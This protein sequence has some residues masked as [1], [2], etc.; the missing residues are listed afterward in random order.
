M[1]SLRLAGMGL[2][3][4]RSKGLGLLFSVREGCRFV[5]FLARDGSRV[6][7]FCWHSEQAAVCCVCMG[8]LQRGHSGCPGKGLSPAHTNK[9]GT[10]VST[11][12]PVYR[13]NL[14]P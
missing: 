8:F 3:G 5:V 7:Q 9:L 11:T 1:G 13:A 2:G 6:A 14:C 4:S 12:L 10:L